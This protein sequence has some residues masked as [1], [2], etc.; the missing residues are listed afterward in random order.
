MPP[1]GSVNLLFG[2][3]PALLDGKLVKL[4]PRGPE[5]VALQSLVEFKEEMFAAGVVA[6]EVG[7]TLVSRV[8]FALFRR[9]CL[10]SVAS[11]QFLKPIRTVAVNVAYVKR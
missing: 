4:F 10:Q 6:G 8:A 3:R 7:S 11:S 9:Q 2:Q 1:E 5:G